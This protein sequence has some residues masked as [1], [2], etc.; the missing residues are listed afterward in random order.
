MAYSAFFIET[1]TTS[2]GIAPPTMG[3]ALP[4]QTLI[5]KVPY[6]LAYSLILWRYFIN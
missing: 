4:Y 1:R 3:W 2:P 6:R 5:K